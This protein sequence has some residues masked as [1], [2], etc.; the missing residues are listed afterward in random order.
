M[1]QSA[2]SPRTSNFNHGW[3]FNLGDVD[4]A[5][6]SSFDDG[7]WRSLSLP[8]DWSVEHPFD[9]KLEGCT[10]YLPGGIGWYRKT[11]ATPESVPGGRTLVVFDGVYNRSEIWINGKSL[12]FRPYG[13]VPIVLDL[14]DHLA[15]AGGENVLAVRVDHSHYGDSRWYT[16][17][18]IYRDVE[19]IQVGPT[20][21]PVWGTFVTTPKV[22][23]DEAQVQ[24]ETQINHTGSEAGGGSLSTSILDP[25][26]N[27]VAKASESVSLAG[28]SQQAV[29][30]QLAVAQPKRWGIETPHMYRAVTT[31]EKGGEVVDRYETPFGIRTI[32][33]DK[34]KG[35]FLNEEHTLIKGVCL[36]HD[37]G[38]VGAAVPLG[39]WRRRLLTLREGGCNAIRTAHNPPSAEFLD[40]C[41]EMGFL[42]QDEFYDEWDNPK[43]KRQNCNEKERDDIVA[44]HDEFFQ[45]W[46]ERDLKDTMLRDRN[47]PCVFQWS[48]GNEIEWTY[49]NYSK[50]T[51]FFDMDWTGNYFWSQPPIG[52]EEIKKRILETETGENGEHVCATT[53]QKLAAWTRELDST[54]PITANCILP[55]ASHAS[56][57]A[58]ALDVVGY[59]YRRVMYDY[60]QEISDKCIMGTENVPHWHEWKAVLDREF[61]SG[62]FLWTGIDYMGESNKK[63]PTKSTRSG[64]LSTAG[65]AKP[66]YHLYKT[67][68][69]DDPHAQLFTIPLEDSV[70]EVGGDGELVEKEP[71]SWERRLWFWHPL[72]PHWEYEPGQK[73][74]VEAMTNMPSAELLL[75]GEKLGARKLEDQ[76]DRICRWLV[77]Y[78]PGELSIQATDG[79][80]TAEHTLAA[81]GAVADISLSVDREQLVADGRDVAHVVAQLVDAEGRPVRSDEREIVF[82]LGEGLRLLGVDNGAH[83]NTQSY[84]S[85]RLVTHHGRA[86]LVVQAAAEA[87]Q[88]SITATTAGAASA[89]VSLEL[90][91]SSDTGVLQPA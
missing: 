41:D 91:G 48:I 33:F 2:S 42:V 90:T 5:S 19:L 13:Y 17:S 76:D 37:G 22:T 12:G 87:S 55:S 62:L 7:A 15:D 39:V 29:T 32:Q 36:H 73:I 88:V 38:L 56:G 69:S 68:W 78:Q 45:E 3:R 70:Y 51:G 34:H 61:I 16:G 31:L 65:F 74:V 59:S 60:G 82:E 72:N 4:A 26:G 9:E 50:A 35:F 63:W 21:I 80:A 66:S 20:H 24:I 57:Y 28:G 75:N 79:Q 49:P 46:A 86:L 43:D 30:Q 25:Q 83:D 6:Q 40:L 53:A 27:E 44:G 67:L 10:G 81:P 54:R 18:G 47:H 1:S 89:S 52:P 11:F 64:L 85:D 58:D 84:T 23:D 8:H 14:T 77:E 71:G